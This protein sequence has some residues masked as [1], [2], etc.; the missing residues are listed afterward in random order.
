MYGIATLSFTASSIT[1]LRVEYMHD[2]SDGSKS[3]MGRN[4]TDIYFHKIHL[5]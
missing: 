4:G 2:S 1:N 3:M 5:F